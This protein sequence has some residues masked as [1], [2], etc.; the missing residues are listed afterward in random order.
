[1]NNHAPVLIVARPG[2]M[3]DGLQALLA[4]M[5]QI[6]SVDLTDDGP[7]ALSTAPNQHPALVLLDTR[8]SGD[9]T[10]AVL[11][12]IKTRWPLAR[13]LLL[14]DTDRQRRLARAAGADGVLLKGFQADQL[15]A[16][17]EGLLK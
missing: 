5:P 9:E 7:S 2:R 4:A 6:G 12:Q 17:V 10:L 16:T 11:R 13:C 14:V 8:T 3:R 1:M 15:F